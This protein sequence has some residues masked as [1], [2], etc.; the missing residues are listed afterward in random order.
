MPSSLQQNIT[1]LQAYNTLCKN[2]M[3]IIKNNI[4]EFNYLQNN[5]CIDAINYIKKTIS[6]QNVSMYQHV[7]H[8]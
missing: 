2:N 3:S 7:P 8:Q 1:F 5:K 4:V 6:I